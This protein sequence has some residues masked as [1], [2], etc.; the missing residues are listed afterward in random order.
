MKRLS[1]KKLVKDNEKDYIY[2]DE[3]HRGNAHGDA[4]EG[5]GCD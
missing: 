4:G 5:S 3:L 1:R 2:N